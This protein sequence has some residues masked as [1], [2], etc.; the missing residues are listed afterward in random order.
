MALAP[1]DTGRTS[2]AAEA[3]VTER[4]LPPRGEYW[5]IEFERDEYPGPRLRAACATWRGCS[6]ARY[7]EIHALELAHTRRAVDRR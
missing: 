1:S 5:T 3:L 2:G 4:R 6:G 7:Q